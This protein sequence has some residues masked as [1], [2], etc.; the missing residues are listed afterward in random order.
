LRTPKTRAPSAAA[1]TPP[2]GQEYAVLEV[3]DDGA[4]IDP[5]ILERLFEESF[6]TRASGN[7]LG[8]AI[9]RTVA[10]QARGRV[11]VE[12]AVG[13]GSVFRVLLPAC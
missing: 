4:G 11:E 8:L 5:A 9:V 6:T 13:R 1:G 3:S 12:S 10:E 7:G 2:S